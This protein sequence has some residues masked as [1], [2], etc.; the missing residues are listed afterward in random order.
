M[1]DGNMAEKERAYMPQGT[2][3]LI[4]YFETEEGIKL[5]PQHVIIATVFFTGLVLA[6]K[7]LGP[8]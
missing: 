5:K 7:F 6:S 3:G 1:L 4:R 8:I 2:A